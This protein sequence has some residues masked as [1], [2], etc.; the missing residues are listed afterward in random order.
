M[1]IT[2][3]PNLII[4]TLTFITQITCEVSLLGWRDYYINSNRATVRSMTVEGNSI[5][6][7]ASYNNIASYM[8]RWITPDIGKVLS[9]TFRSIYFGSVEYANYQI[10]AHRKNIFNVS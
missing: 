9:S 1:I 7:I 2:R 3:I 6:L 5:V 8:E 10:R 4:L